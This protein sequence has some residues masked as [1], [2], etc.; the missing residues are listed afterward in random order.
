VITMTTSTDSRALRTGRP[1][2]PVRGRAGAALAGLLLAA[3]LALAGPAAP[4]AAGT[5]ATSA[6]ATPHTGFA[7]NEVI[8]RPVAFRVTNTNRTELPCVADGATYTVRGRIVGQRRELV[9][10]QLHRVLLHV[11][12][13]GTGRWFWNLRAQ[14][15]VDH[16][17]AMA[18]LGHVSVVLDRLGYD[19]SGSLSDGS[20]T[21]FGAQADMLHQVVQ[22]LRA[23]R[24]RSP[25]PVRTANHV[26]TVGHA[27]GA[28]IAQLESATFGDVAGLVQMS[29]TNSAPSPTALEEAAGQHQRCATGGE[30]GRGRTG[31]AF[32]TA[33]AADFRGLLF[34][35]ASPRVQ[36][37]ASRLRNPDPCGDALSLASLAAT[38]SALAGQVRPPVLL[39][40]GAEDQRN[41][42]ELRDAHVASFAN[43]MEIDVSVVPRAG[44]ALPLEANAART[45]AVLSAWLCRELSCPPRYGARRR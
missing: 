40:F 9:R 38:N 36:A 5:T 34:R 13:V 32:H 17:R 27:V 43:A 22:R 10:P 14:P 21:C 12:D 2:V 8:S 16:A 33:T 20:G 24:Y 7:P 6:A 45:R 1:L 30:Q 42:A 29:W 18:R 28:G 3:P 39:L 15:S 26:V 11:H 44:S 4:T 25:I 35:T 37:T 41:T 31:Y 19:A 23:G